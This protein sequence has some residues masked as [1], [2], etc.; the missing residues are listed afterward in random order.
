MIV[1]SAAD[2]K[3]LRADDDGT[4]V[5]ADSWSHATGPLND[6]AVDGLG[7]IYVGNFGYD[8]HAGDPPKTTSI[9]RVDTDGTITTVADNVDF[10]NG[11]V[12]IDNGRTLVVAE[13]WVSRLTAFDLDARGDLSNRRLFADL[14]DRQPDGICA[15]AE[16][17][18]W[19]GCYNTGEF[20]RV[21]DG[22]TTTDRLQFE[23]HAISCTLGGEDGRQLFMTVF[24]GPEDDIA[25]GLHKSAVFTAVV[26][27]PGH[28][29][30]QR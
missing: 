18:I 30:A 10:P 6:F 14:G 28:G 19:A 5:Y 25:A 8:I 4:S 9:H 3:L 24:L 21:L 11:S 17:A 12:V 16:G 15:D 23:G 13:T 2:R 22:G 27:V 1:A 26:D 7:R 20:V 29:I